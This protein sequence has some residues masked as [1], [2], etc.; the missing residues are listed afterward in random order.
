[1]RSLVKLAAAFFFSPLSFVIPWISDSSGPVLSRDKPTSELLVEIISE[2]QKSEGVEKEWLGPYADLYGAGRWV[3]GDGID[4]LIIYLA[5]RSFRDRKECSACIISRW[6]IYR[7]HLSVRLL[8][9][10][11]ELVGRRELV[12]W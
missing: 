11:K 2:S 8:L 12:D 1:M 4:R 5:Q 3:M 10:D 6:S 9:G 7:C